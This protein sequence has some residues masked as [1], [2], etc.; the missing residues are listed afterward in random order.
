MLIKR[1]RDDNAVDAAGEVAR[2]HFERKYSPQIAE[3]K[4]VDV[5]AEAVERFQ[6]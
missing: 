6:A 5:Y 4:L 2:R 1:L 3:G